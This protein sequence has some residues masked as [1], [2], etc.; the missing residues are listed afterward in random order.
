MTL[1]LAKSANLPAMLMDIS[2]FT[3]Q[4]GRKK[5]I[6]KC[7]CVTNVTSYCLCVLLWFT[8]MFSGLLQKNLFKGG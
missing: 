1:K 4:D 8:L 7:M 2:E 6:A 3:Q 5:R